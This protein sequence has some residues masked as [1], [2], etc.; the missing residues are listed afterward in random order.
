VKATTMK[1]TGTLERLDLGGGVW[2]LAATDGRRFALQAKPKVASA[3]RAGA[4]VTVEGEPV[5]VLGVGMTGDPALA[6]TKVV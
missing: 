3:F 5:D 4:K 6:V 2:V 1:V